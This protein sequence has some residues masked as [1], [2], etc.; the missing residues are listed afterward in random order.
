ML[1]TSGHHI[2]VSVGQGMGKGEEGGEKSVI[3]LFSKN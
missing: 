3:Y 1:D 2:P